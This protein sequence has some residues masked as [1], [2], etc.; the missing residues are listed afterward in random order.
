MPGSVNKTYLLTISVL[1]AAAACCSCLLI[2]YG[3][4]HANF[5]HYPTLLHRLPY[6]PFAEK[7]RTILYGSCSIYAR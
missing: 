4:Y 3:R 5:M 7:L 6:V 1:F 2:P